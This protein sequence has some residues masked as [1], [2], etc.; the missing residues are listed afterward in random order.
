MSH[1]EGHAPHGKKHRSSAPHWTARHLTWKTGVVVVLAVPFLIWTLAGRVPWLSSKHPTGAPTFVNAR[2]LDPVHAMRPATLIGGHG[3][4]A[5][6]SDYVG[7][8]VLL[9]LGYTHCPDICPGNLAFLG[10]ELRRLGAKAKQI[11]VVFVSVDPERDRQVDMDKYAQYFHPDFVGL[12]VTDDQLRTIVQ[13]LGTKI[14][15]E[16]PSSP[17]QPYAVDHPATTYVLDPQGR[18]VAVY[19]L[20]DK[21]G[22]IAE[23]FASL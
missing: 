23:D 9:S 2:R 10:G 21:P 16:V 3:R 14:E 12:N 4:T 7:K 22:Q 18:E 13:D 5:R 1:P 19:P 15:R 20:L 8:W 6:L 17:G 11:Q